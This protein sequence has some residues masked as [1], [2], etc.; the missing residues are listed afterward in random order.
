M[1]LRIFA[2]AAL[3]CSIG[4]MFKTIVDT[5]DNHYK[6]KLMLNAALEN[7]KN[8]STKKKTQK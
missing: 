1:D 3:G 8:E 2:A 4:L 7:N 5:I 6:M